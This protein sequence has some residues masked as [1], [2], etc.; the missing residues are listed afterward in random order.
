M[1]DL[2]PVRFGIVGC[3]NASVPVGEALIRSPLTELVGV[4]DVND[5]L[6]SDLGSRFHA[7]KAETFDALLDDPII[8]SIYI[9]VPH[10]LLGRL[11]KRVLEAGK[12]ALVEKPLALT[13]DEVDEL[14]NWQRAGDR[15]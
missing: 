5:D 14:I 12:H 13:L 6:A 10:F 1:P 8:D 15:F 7:Q 11:T 4:Y 2:K 9:A 3:G